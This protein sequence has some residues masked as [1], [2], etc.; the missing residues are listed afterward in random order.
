MSP[1]SKI[2]LYA[3]LGISVSFALNFSIVDFINYFSSFCQSVYSEAIIETP[4]QVAAILGGSCF[5][6]VV[7]GLI[8]GVMD[9]ED[10]NEYD[11]RYA[12][13]N[14]EHYCYPIGMVIGGICGAYNE[15][16]RKQNE[17]S[18]PGDP[19]DQEI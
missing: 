11:I 19:F 13:M 10:V 16:I 18:R 3:I 8:F 9:I 7:F 12:L 6:G 15:Y 1:N 17:Y 2:P 4:K 5:M 14:E